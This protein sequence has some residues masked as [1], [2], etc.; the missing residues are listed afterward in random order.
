MEAPDK[1]GRIIINNVISLVGADLIFISFT[2]W[3]WST[4]FINNF[5]YLVQ[6]GL[7][8]DV[9]LDVFG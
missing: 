2:S 7:N 3:K 9:F 6:L 4:S 5:F 1:N 8:S